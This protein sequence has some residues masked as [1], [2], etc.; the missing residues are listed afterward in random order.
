[1]REHTNLDRE[2]TP[3]PGADLILIV[4][5]GILNGWNVLGWLKAVYLNFPAKGALYCIVLHSFAFLEFL[6]V[7]VMV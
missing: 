3:A 5:H 2:W 1:M 7:V 4:I 6:G